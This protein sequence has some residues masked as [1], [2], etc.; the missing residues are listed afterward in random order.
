MAVTMKHLQH[1]GRVSM[2][3]STSARMVPACRPV[4]GPAC[5]RHAH[6]AAMQGA[7]GPVQA[8]RLCKS[9]PVVQALYA[10]QTELSTGGCETPFC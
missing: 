3:L 8:L 7:L 5:V 10:Q 4:A 6:A 1:M 9:R 2:R